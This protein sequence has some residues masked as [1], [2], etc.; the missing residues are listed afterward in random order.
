MCIVKRTAGGGRRN[1]MKTAD[2]M[3]HSDGEADG[4]LLC[5]VSYEVCQQSGGIYTVLRSKAPA[6]VHEW[7]S[8]YCLVGPWNPQLSP[9]EFEE[10]K[11]TGDLAAAIREMQAKGLVVKTGI[12][13]V[14]GRPRV[15]LVDPTC[16]MG[17]LAEIEYLLWEHHHIG[18]LGAEP[19][20]HQ[21]TA[22]GWLVQ[23]FFKA[24]ASVVGHRRIIGH[25]HEW[26]AGSAIPEL[27]R[28]QVPVG[29]VFTTHATLLG[30]YL[31]MQDSNFYD[32]VPF[33]DW[34]ADAK[35]FNVEPQVL[36][37][38]AA[39]HG[40]HVFTTVSDITAFEC[41]HLL[42]RKPDVILPNGLNIQRF[43]AIHEFQNLHRIY[44]EKIH[45]FVMGHFFPSYTFDLDKTLYL[46]TSGRY[47]Y[48][49]KGFDMTL[50]AMARLNERL[51][52]AQEAQTVV[53]FIVTRRS[54]RSVN[55]EVLQ[56]QAVLQEI[57]STCEAIKDQVG[58]RLFKASAEG[59][60]PRLDELV[61]EYWRLR[62]RRTLLAWKTPRLPSV[63]THDLEDD[64]HDE[65]L[66]KIRASG[67]FNLAEDRVKIVYHPDFVSA[68]SPLFG[69]DY[70]QF[71]RGS[72]LGLFPSYYEPWGYAPLESMALGVPAVTSDLAGFGTYVMRE[73]EGLHL[74]GMRVIHRRHN[75][76]ETAVQ[77][78]TNACLNFVRL[79][80]RDRIAMRNEVE[81]ASVEFDWSKL[82]R[83]YAEAHKMA[84]ARLGG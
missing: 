17:R 35:R 39:A 60:W 4:P 67:L 61:D 49:N 66:N 20:A 13:L 33:V 47:E 10:T 70:D 42:G 52:A 1:T 3:K 19:L 45:A 55:A 72:H 21:V 74:R 83:H 41:E 44:K 43:A 69:M 68:T 77:E 76:Y 53:F 26:M 64:Q 11:P 57:H 56:K 25:F 7:G 58:E 24:L 28:E 22:F 5:E 23:E 78:L 81:N 79:S 31:A 12:W 75:S 36:I 9:A 40:A 71:V 6:M 51:K 2:V 29:I 59:T 63:V 16:A 82:G 46:F 73:M 50:D 65:V 14:T 15:V 8:R 84:L 37:E 48:V 30:R 62:L 27:R 80:R 54:C 38:R 18:M 34:R 32:H